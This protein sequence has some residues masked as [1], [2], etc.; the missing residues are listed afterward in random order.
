MSGNMPE[1]DRTNVFLNADSRGRITTCSVESVAMDHY[2]T[3]Y[4]LNKGE[5][6]NF[7]VNEIVL[8][9]FFFYKL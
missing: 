4:D 8:V 2:M 5:S 1:S 7:T 9:F 6:H 3:K